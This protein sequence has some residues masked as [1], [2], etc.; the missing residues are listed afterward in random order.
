VVFNAT[1]GSG[2]QL[3]TRSLD[4]LEL[5]SV[6]G[7]EGATGTPFWSSDSRWIIFSTLGKLKKA[8]AAGGSAQTLCDISDPAFGGFWTADNRIVFGGPPGI[9]QVPAQGGVPSALTVPDR[10][11]AERGHVEPAPLP[12]GVHFL[13]TR[14]APGSDGTGIYIGALNR[15]PDQQDHKRLLPELSF[16]EYLADPAS[17]NGFLRS[18]VGRR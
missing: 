13:Y 4:S 14:Y 11:H 10:E 2:N 18:R 1:T 9:L 7:S 3:W 17:R 15:K 5:R 8:D 16:G 12:D 6:P